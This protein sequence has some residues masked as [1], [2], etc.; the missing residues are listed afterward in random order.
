MQ[1]MTLH[2][3]QR[4]VIALRTGIQLRGQHMFECKV[5]ALMR[6]AP[7]EH[8]LKIAATTEHEAARMAA[9]TVAR[10][11]WGDAGQPGFI[12]EVAGEYLASVGEHQPC[13]SGLNTVGFTV[14][15]KVAHAQASA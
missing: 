13:D 6:D 12:Q 8:T 1:R 10:M 3:W 9:A 7:P 2:P 15:I 14:A 5:R 11:V 4:N